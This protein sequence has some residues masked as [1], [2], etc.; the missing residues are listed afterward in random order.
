MRLELI[1]ELPI[2]TDTE[3]TARA[4]REIRVLARAEGLTTYDATYLEL[5]IRRG[6][7]LQTKDEALI[8]APSEAA[9]RFS[10]DFAGFR[11]GS[12]E[13]ERDMSNITA[14]AQQ[15]FEA[16][17]AGKGWEVCQAEPCSIGATV[18]S[19]PPGKRCAMDHFS[20]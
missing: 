7:P 3:T 5:A 17:E 18:S 8:A 11:P 4:W 16:C 15:F 14:V 6:L 2:A 13:E 20:R 1:A 10:A 19:S 12:R 9:R